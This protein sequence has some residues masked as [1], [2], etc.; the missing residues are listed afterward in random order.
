MYL[1]TLQ[2]VESIQ[3]Q[4]LMDAS[5]LDAY[6]SLARYTD[7]QYQQIVDYMNSP[8]F[9]AKQTLM[10]QAKEDAEGLRKLG[11]RLENR[12]DFSSAKNNQS[13]GSCFTLQS[14]DS[15]FAPRP[16]T[17]GKKTTTQGYPWCSG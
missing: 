12:S 11:E 4:G 1:F 10:K 6:L 2:A 13:L 9:E 7:A 8:T 16:F 15:C 5:S 17:I 14:L 3:S